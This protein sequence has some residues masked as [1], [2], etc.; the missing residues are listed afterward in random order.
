MS[1]NEQPAK[2]KPTPV[3][4]IP[5]WMAGVEDG[6]HEAFAYHEPDLAIEFAKYGA[7]FPYAPQKDQNGRP[8]LDPSDDDKAHLHI[9][10]SAAFFNNVFTIDEWKECADN[11]PNKP[12]TETQLQMRDSADVKVRAHFLKKA[13]PKFLKFL[14]APQGMA[15]DLEA[16]LNLH[17]P[18]SAA[19]RA[20]AQKYLIE[21][22]TAGAR[23]IARELPKSLNKVGKSVN[24]DHGQISK[25]LKNGQLVRPS[26]NYTPTLE[27]NSGACG[28]RR[29][30]KA[31]TGQTG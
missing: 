3:N 19:I 21:N 26:Q 30:R 9:L 27:K 16:I 29:R 14:G 18:R 24:A 17:K 31:G 2:P 25:D 15:E 4:G 20:M 11:Y 6:F 10:I 22:P 8:I 5:E 7:A 28:S 13:L 1:S 12:L 23:A